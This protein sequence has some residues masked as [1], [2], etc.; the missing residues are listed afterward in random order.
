MFL[1]VLYAVALTALLF[2]W[3][4]PE[5]RL[6]IE[7]HWNRILMNILNINIRLRGLT[8]DLSA[9]NLML[10]ANHVSWLDIYVLN[11][12]RPVRFVSKSE[13]RAW[14]VVGWLASRTGTLFI[15]RSKRHDTARLN[16][17]MSDLLNQGACLGIFP[18]GTTSNGSVVRAFHSSLLQPAIMSRSRVCP[19]AIRYT[20]E[21]GMLNEA[22][23][24]IDDLSFIDSLALILGQKI[25]HVEVTFL[26]L[27]E[28][29]NKTRR[30]LA[31]ESE[32]AISL[33]LNLTVT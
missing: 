17:E 21:N 27:I 9:Q 31:R 6:R 22:P 23:A 29:E 18:E 10:V 19:V 1:H 3:V 8:P 7:Q 28:A 12:V 5:F 2:P 30:E 20:H 15:D 32:Q 26:P 14:P 25:I 11:A 13:V 33:A 4:R 24:Y 16:R